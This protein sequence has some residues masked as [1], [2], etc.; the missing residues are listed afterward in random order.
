ML[1]FLKGAWVPF[2]SN[3]AVQDL[4]MMKLRMRSRPLVTA[5]SGGIR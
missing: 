1:R 5:C 2:R 3:Q 4:R